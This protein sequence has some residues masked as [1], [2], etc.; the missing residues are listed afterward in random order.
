MPHR[1]TSGV[2]G[3]AGAVEFEYDAGGTRLVKRSKPCTSGVRRRERARG[4]WWREGHSHAEV[5]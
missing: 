3:A 5:S 1:I 2:N 4:T